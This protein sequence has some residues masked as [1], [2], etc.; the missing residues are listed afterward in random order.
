[1]VEGG[2]RKEPGW[3]KFGK[4][5]KLFYTNATSLQIGTRLPKIEQATSD[6]KKES[7]D[8]VSLSETGYNWRKQLENSAKYSFSKIKMLPR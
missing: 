4:I 1:M 2:I 8:L 5:I 7:V 3:E 6:L